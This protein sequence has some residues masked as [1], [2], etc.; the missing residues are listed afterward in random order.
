M[1]TQ[2]AKFCAGSDG[3]AD[4]HSINS[5]VT[6]ERKQTRISTWRVEQVLLDYLAVKNPVKLGF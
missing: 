4:T 6:P 1:R 5:A 2:T 3:V